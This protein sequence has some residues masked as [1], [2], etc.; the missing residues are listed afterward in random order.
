MPFQVRA[1]STIA[2]LRSR[3]ILTSPRVVFPRILEVLLEVAHWCGIY[4]GG[5]KCDEGG[6]GLG[7]IFAIFF[8]KS[9][10]GC[11]QEKLETVENTEN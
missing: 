11:V 2:F 7:G 9:E 1:S 5:G 3:Q 8:R 10:N 4:G 6:R